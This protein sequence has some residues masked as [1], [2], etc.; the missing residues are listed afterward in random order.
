MKKVLFIIIAS[1]LLYGNAFSDESAELLF[2]KANELYKSEE[3]ENALQMYQT[4]IDKGY[5]NPV[6]TYNLGNIYFKLNQPA[7]ARVWYERTLKMQPNHEDALYN[8]NIL[9]RNL[10]DVIKK[11]PHAFDFVITLFERINMNYIFYPLILLLHLFFLASAY[12]IL[13]KKKLRKLISL[14]VILLLFFAFFSV[15]LIIKIKI[16]EREFGI[17]LQDHTVR[18]GPG[19]SYTPAFSIHS[20]TKVQIKNKENDWLGITLENGLSGW[21]KKEAI[22]K[23]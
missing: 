8:I 13:T 2:D 6:F 12:Q 14:Y 1:V 16:N 4:L 11:E 23:I 19:D 21:I 22:E 9:K 20:G 17:I 18:N 5:N 15:G 3:Y 10:K 7:Q